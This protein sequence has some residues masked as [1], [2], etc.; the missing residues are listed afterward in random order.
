[1]FPQCPVVGEEPAEA[2]LGTE[3][4]MPPVAQFTSSAGLGGVDCYAGA[5]QEGGAVSSD[6]PQARF[7][8]DPGEFMAGD[9][10]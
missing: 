7:L 3:I 5:G 8:D 4:G 2:E 9:Q 6:S 10:R 1:M